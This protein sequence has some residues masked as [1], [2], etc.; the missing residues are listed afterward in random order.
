MYIEKNI[1]TNVEAEHHDFQ[2]IP[3]LPELWFG[4][5][6][7]SPILVSFQA[8]VIFHWTIIMGETVYA[9]PGPGIYETLS[10]MG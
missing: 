4:R 3:F 8:K 5:N 10:I 2:Q 7:M 1:T 9:P 6:G